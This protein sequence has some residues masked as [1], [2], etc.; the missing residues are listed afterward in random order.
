MYVL[1]PIGWLF[2]LLATGLAFGLRPPRTDFP[3]RLVIVL[4]LYS[5]LVGLALWGVFGPGSFQ[6]LCEWS[7]DPEGILVAI[8]LDAIIVIGSVA[9]TPLWGCAAGRAIR[10]YR[11]RGT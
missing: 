8:M 7:G 6:R 2:L 3:T 4:S 11:A 10:W 1:L 9:L 5:A